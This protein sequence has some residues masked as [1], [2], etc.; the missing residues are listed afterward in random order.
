MVDTGLKGFEVACPV[1]TITEEPPCLS[2]HAVIISQILSKCSG[3]TRELVRYGGW[4]GGSVSSQ[5]VSGTLAHLLRS[6]YVADHAQ[7]YA[8]F[9]VCVNCSVFFAFVRFKTKAN[10]TNGS[11]RLTLDPVPPL[12]E[13]RMSCGGHIG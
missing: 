1:R 8:Y 4:V 10:Q 5:S 11:N 13:G 2:A 6:Q 3:L 9:K 12:C 7:P